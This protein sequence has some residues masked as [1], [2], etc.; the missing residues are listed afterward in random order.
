MLSARFR[1]RRVESAAHR[2]EHRQLTTMRSEKLQILAQLFSVI[3]TAPALQAQFAR[4]D[5]VKQEHGKCSL[6]LRGEWIDRKIL[7][8]EHGGLVGSSNPASVRR[9]SNAKSSHS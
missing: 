2:R 7:I 6:R 9:K 1:S 4:G 8:G 3:K 5:C